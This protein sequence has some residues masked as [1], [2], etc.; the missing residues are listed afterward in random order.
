MGAVPPR[1]ESRAMSEDAA[2]SSRRTPP[3]RRS[4]KTRPL[5]LALPL[6]IAVVLA[7]AP[8][9]EAKKRV[10]QSHVLACAAMVGA[11]CQVRLHALERFAVWA[12]LKEK[13]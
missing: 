12:Q 1:V 8:G 3:K 4:G 11:P 5:A 9:A 13:N 6:S 10:Q 7:V 2:R